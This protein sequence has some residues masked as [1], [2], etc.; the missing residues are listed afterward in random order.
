M[1]NPLINV[2]FTSVIV[3][4]ILNDGREASYPGYQ[5]QKSIVIWHSQTDWENAEQMNFAQ[6][7]DSTPMV[8]IAVRAW[9]TAGPIDFEDFPLATAMVLR[10]K[11]S[12]CLVKAALQKRCISHA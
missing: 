3:G 12:L 2:P 9:H 7:P 5:R 8:V 4:L 1:N 6:S 10:S 11:E